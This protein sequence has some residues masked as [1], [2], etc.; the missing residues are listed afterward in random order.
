[1]SPKAWVRLAPTNLFERSDLAAEYFHNE[2]FDKKTFGDIRTDSP[3]IV[4]NATDLSLGQSFS[5][6]DYHFNWIC[7]DLDSYPIS[8]AVAAS[9]AVPVIF[10]PIT[11][12]N[13]ASTCRT[14]PVVWQIQDN[15][16]IPTL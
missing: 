2:I 10:S 6:T 8:R 3:T 16:D 5:F 4:I 9:A 1:L 12:Q 15:D 13:H 7:S 11:L 14:S